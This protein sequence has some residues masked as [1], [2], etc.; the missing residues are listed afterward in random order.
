MF[1][2]LHVFI[3]VIEKLF[4]INFLCKSISIYF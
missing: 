1:S 3:V 4:Q 2:Y